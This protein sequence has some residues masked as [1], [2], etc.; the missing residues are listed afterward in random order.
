MEKQ[1]SHKESR[2]KLASELYDRHGLEQQAIALIESRQ[3]PEHDNWELEPDIN[4]R[5]AI[6]EEL[7]AK[8]HLSR[9]EFDEAPEIANQRALRRLIN[10]WSDSLPM[11]EME[12]RLY[13]VVEE[14]TIHK[15]WEDIEAGNLPEDTFVITLS[16]FP[17]MCPDDEAPKI[18]YRALNKKG[19][20]RTTEFNGGKRVI[21]QVSRS[22]SSDGSSERFFSANGFV[23]GRGSARTL[24]N[25]VIATKRDFP[26]GVVDVQKALDSLAGPHMI[27]GENRNQADFNVPEYEDLRS[28]SSAREEQAE[29]FIKRL[30]DYEKE[31][32]ELYR[33]GKIG[34]ADKFN[35]FN[36]HRKHL[37][38]QICV[39]DPSYA[40]DARGE[41]AVV[42][43]EEASVALASGDHTAGAAHL[44]QALAVSDPNAGVVCG[45]VLPENVKAQLSAETAQTYR[46]ALQERKN[47]KWKKGVCVVKEC[48]T[49]PSKTEVGPCSVC[50][51][52]QAI[53]DK[54]KNPKK[55]YKAVGF[56]ETILNFQTNE[57]KKSVKSYQ[58][59]RR[60]AA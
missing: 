29:S 12:R 35:S 56:W 51:K 5:T 54:G 10:G 1:D 17:E 37:V 14:L 48:P 45:G 2:P 57:S 24:A 52:C 36:K 4:A 44:E 28:V 34:Y 41:A 8:G 33:A 25:Q 3:K 59:G 23:V 7:T 22:N 6:F 55:L 32:N 19:M 49:R 38:D 31:L 26:N 60:E 43:F 27:Y 13:E 50:R 46:E 15:V 18:G 58:E 30:A 39:L 21:E 42:H 9:V 47:W 11:W 16:D 20:V 40:K 53:F